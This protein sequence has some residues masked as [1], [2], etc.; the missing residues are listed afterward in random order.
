MVIFNPFEHVNKKD[1]KKRVA[2]LKKK[3]P[4]LSNEEICR[5]LIRK[6]SRWCTAAGVVTTMPGTVPVLGTLFV[7]VGGTALDL[8][9]MAFLL[10]ELI[11][12]VAEVYNR[13]L[14]LDMTSREAVWVLISSIGSSAAGRGLS[15][16]TVAQLSGSTF[17]GWW[18]TP[19]WP[20]VS[21][22][23]KNSLEGDSRIGMVVAGWV[24]YYT[25]NKVGS[26]VIKHHSENANP[27]SWEGNHR[28]GSICRIRINIAGF[29]EPVF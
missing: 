15:S 14:D 19:Y 2:R 22:R 9:A 4:H 23:P 17:C 25:C 24:N 21:G 3:N 18:S 10:T 26:F 1:V 12:E 16:L 29:L 13:N 11:L 5:I 27:D 6:K 8:T 20:W 7:I 28:C